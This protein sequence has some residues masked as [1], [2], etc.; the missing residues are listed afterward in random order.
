MS[1][2]PETV[3][4]YIQIWHNNLSPLSSSF[5]L[6]GSAWKSA[7]KTWCWWCFCGW[8]PRISQCPLTSF[9]TLSEE[10]K[11]KKCDMW[12]GTCDPWHVTRVM[13]H[14]T[15]DTGHD[16]EGGEPS[17]KMSAPYLLGMKVCWRYSHKGSVSEWVSKLVIDKDYCRTA[18]ASL[19]L[20][21]IQYIPGFISQ[22]LA[23]SPCFKGVESAWMFPPTQFFLIF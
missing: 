20:L 7:L 11:E 4:F 22:G 5:W 9:T 17:L 2:I 16:M 23:N 8:E 13:W 15:P 21:T 18:P 12:D 10:K 1:S 19:G 14:L 3:N 6:C